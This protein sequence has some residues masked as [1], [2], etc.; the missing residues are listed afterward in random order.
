MPYCTNTGI[1][2]TVE[3]IY[4]SLAAWCETESLTEACKMCEEEYGFWLPR[5]LGKLDY[6]VQGKARG[7]WT[8]GIAHWHIIE[9]SYWEISMHVVFVYF[10]IMFQFNIIWYT[11]MYTILTVPS[12]L[13]WIILHFLSILLLLRYWL[14][15]FTWSQGIV[16]S[17]HVVT[18]TEVGHSVYISL[19][20]WHPTIT[21]RLFPQLY[22]I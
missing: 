9:V 10:Y 13:F 21:V 11:F 3:Q 6:Y 7:K 19:S 16:E 2:Y 18:L 22:G 20:R 1:L 17:V 8:R 4:F 14:T 5:T 15:I 12:V